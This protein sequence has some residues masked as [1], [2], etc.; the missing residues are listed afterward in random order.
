MNTLLLLPC[1][2]HDLIHPSHAVEWNFFRHFVTK[3]SL[4]VLTYPPRGCN[5]LESCLT[6]MGQS[7]YGI[8]IMVRQLYLDL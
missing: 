2:Q 3:T 1:Y 5:T 8:W 7:C 4:T 6:L